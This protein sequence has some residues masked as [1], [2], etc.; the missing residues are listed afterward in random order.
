[1]VKTFVTVIRYLTDQQRKL[2]PTP[3]RVVEATVTSAAMMA[4]I[5]GAVAAAKPRLRPEALIG[6]LWEVLGK[7][8]FLHATVNRPNSVDW[9]V[10][11]PA[12][13]RTYRGVATTEDYLDQLA[14]LVDP[15]QPT[16]RCH[17]R[18]VHWTSRMRW[19][20]WTRYG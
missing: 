12:V 4:E 6:K 7:V 15:A 19:A 2:V 10:R 1:M 20:T 3:D 17:H 18:S 13:L 5:V 16:P 11:V 9:E 8:P 14:E